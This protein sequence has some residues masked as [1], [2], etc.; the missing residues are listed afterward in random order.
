MKQITVLVDD[1]VGVLAD[2]S[3]LLGK[4]KINIESID[5]V[6]AGGKGVINVLVKDESS[7]VR[8]LTS[9]GYKVLQT[10]V[11]VVQMPDTP[12]E[13]SKMSKML[14]ENGVNIEAVHMLTRGDGKTIYT[15]KLD[16]QPKGEKLLE[17]YI[18]PK[19]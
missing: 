3:F 6:V 9:N 7:A 10:D 1:K 15:L 14:A 19:D 5:V 2:I 17:N 4:A 8:I 11:V 18:H 12:G 13:L 16:K